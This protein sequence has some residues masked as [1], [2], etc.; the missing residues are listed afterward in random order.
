[1]GRSLIT[2]CSN[3]ILTMPNPPPM[4]GLPLCFQT[5]RSGTNRRRPARTFRST[6]RGYAGCSNA[7]GRRTTTLR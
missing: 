6:R 5:F 4:R 7:Q 2:R 3:A 1:M